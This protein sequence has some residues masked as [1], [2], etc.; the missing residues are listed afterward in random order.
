[1]AYGTVGDGAVAVHPG[2]AIVTEAGCEVPVGHTELGLDP[3]KNTHW[4]KG[5]CKHTVS[6]GDEKAQNREEQS[7]RAEDR[8]GSKGISGCSDKL[9]ILLISSAGFPLRL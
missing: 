9:G 7:I 1:M 8:E 5:D 3:A 2:A 6:A 4:K